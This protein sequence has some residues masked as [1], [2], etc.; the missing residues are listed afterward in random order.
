MKVAMFLEPAVFVQNAEL[1]SF[2]NTEYVYV[3]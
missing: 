1:F 3:D 2:T